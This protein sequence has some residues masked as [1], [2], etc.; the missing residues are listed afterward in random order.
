MCRQPRVPMLTLSDGTVSV[1]LGTAAAVAAFHTL[2][3]LDHSI[4]FVVLGRARG[5]SL[6]RTLGVT[7]ACGVAHVAS[8]VLIGSVGVALGVALD[9]LS[10]L[11]SA[12]GQIAAGLMIGFGLA[13]LGLGVGVYL[14]RAG[15]TEGSTLARTLVPGLP[16]ALVGLMSIGGAAMLG[17]RRFLVYAA[18]LVCGGVAVIVIKTHPGWALLA[19]GLAVTLCGFVLMLRFVREYPVASSELD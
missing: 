4:P 15:A 13:T 7:G 1:L 11:E 2:I 19:G 3:G 17:L 12:R 18:V 6:R 10:W 9:R 5:W 8:S 14:S 16:A